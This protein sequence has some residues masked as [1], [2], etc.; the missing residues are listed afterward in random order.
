VKHPTESALALYAGRDLGFGLKLRIGAHMRGCGHCRRRVEQY[1]EV[2][3]WLGGQDEEMPAGVDFDVL[4]AEVKANIRLGLAAGEC[5]AAE[6]EP[7]L[8][9]SR[10][11]P[12]FVLPVLVVVIAG[13]ILQ[14]LQP[15]LRPR[16][17]ARA[18][19]AGV[20]LEASSFGIGLEKDGR[21]LTLLHPHAGTVVSSVRGDALRVRY[22]DSDTGQV[23]I[24]H[25]YAQ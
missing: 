5:V 7:R 12:A 16:A 13:W 19:E 15:P 20:V 2:R 4:A 3:G 14:S 24:S 10:L 21:G 18:S 8:A 11:R 23:T 6:P 22:V 17:T 9:A 25:V 1:R